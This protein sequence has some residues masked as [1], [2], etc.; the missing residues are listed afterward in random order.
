MT[1][2]RMT[3]EEFE[4]L[5]EALF[6]PSKEIEPRRH[7]V[8]SWIEEQSEEWEEVGEECRT[9]RK[10]YGITVKELSSMLGISTTRIYKFENGQPIRD[11][12]LVENAYRMAVTIYQLSRNPM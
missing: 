10:I 6:A 7:D 12:F 2:Y 1:N 9:L 11:A 5:A 3:D 4:T 8:E